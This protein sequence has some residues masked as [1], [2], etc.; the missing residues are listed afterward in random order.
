ST[1]D[2]IA[3]LC[4]GLGL[5][6]ACGF[7]VFV[8]LLGLSIAAMVK[9]VEPAAGWEWIGTWPALICLATATALEIG[10]YYIPWLDNALDSIATPAAAIAGALVS[11]AVVTDLPPL[12][13]WS[14][15]LIAGGGIAGLIQA[16]TVT[17]RGTSTATTGGLANFAVST[18]ELIFAL[19]TTLLA[20][21]LPLIAAGLVLVI[22]AWGM[23]RLTRRKE[24]KRPLVDHS[25]KVT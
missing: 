16:A 9:Y 4:L 8:P 18:G 15:A 20:L 5:S 24:I 17:L 7:R 22:L 11:L 14:L 25:A 21:V 1:I 13:K 19:I 12:W 6:A 23:T 10:A 3:S 2:I